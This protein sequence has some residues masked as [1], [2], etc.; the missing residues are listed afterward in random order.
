[1]D[2]LKDLFTPLLKTVKYINIQAIPSF[3]FIILGVFLVNIPLMFKL[4]KFPPEIE[5]TLM[6]IKTAE[7]KEAISKIEVRQMYRKLFDVLLNEIKIE[8][9]SNQKPIKSDISESI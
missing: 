8:P 4:E 6:F 1:M 3:N 7:K 9:T 2:T 5:R